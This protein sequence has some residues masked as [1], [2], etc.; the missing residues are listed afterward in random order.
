MAP[1]RSE[2]AQGVTIT[3]VDIPFWDL[4]AV[5]FKLAVIWAVFGA[6]GFGIYVLI[7]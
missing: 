5:A 6:I 4:F 3:G 1:D 7:S 2:T